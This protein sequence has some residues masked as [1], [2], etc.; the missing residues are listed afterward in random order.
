MHVKGIERQEGRPPDGDAVYHF[1]G[2]WRGPAA[3]D[4]VHPVA[5]T[6]EVASQ[7]PGIKPDALAGR[8]W[9]REEHGNAHVI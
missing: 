1:T 3:G 2:G 4:Q 7:V 9:C 8:Q 5:L 6:G